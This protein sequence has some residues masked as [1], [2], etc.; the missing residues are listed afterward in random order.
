L[1]ANDG[2]QKKLLTLLRITREHNLDSPR[3]EVALAVYN[4]YFWQAKITVK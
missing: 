2:I 4:D 1:I 3:G